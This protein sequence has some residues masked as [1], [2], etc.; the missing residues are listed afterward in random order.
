VIV[1]VFFKDLGKVIREMKK[2][3]LE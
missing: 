1:K 2:Q 3:I